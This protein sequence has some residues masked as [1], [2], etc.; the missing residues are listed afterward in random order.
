MKN[1][2]KIGIISFR[3][4]D[5]KEPSIQFIETLDSTTVLKGLLGGDL[6]NYDIQRFKNMDIQ[7]IIAKEPNLEKTTLIVS[8]EEDENE[9]IYSNVI[10]ISTLETSNNSLTQEQIDFITQNLEVVM[11]TETKDL[12]FLI[13]D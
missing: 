8:K 7:L 10:F 6:K 5:M 4:H 3:E 9:E 11:N 12:V 1:T 13:Q 2:I